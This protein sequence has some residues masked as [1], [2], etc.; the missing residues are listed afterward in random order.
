MIVDEYT[1]NSVSLHGGRV[2]N[3]CPIYIH[4][5][6]LY[7]KKYEYLFSFILLFKC[8]I[9]L[10]MDSVWYYNGRYAHHYP[11]WRR[12]CTIVYISGVYYE[13]SIRDGSRTNDDATGTYR[14]IGY[15]DTCVCSSVGLD[16]TVTYPHVPQ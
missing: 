14:C 11:K 3:D 7:K 6:A 1:L 9:L 4:V 10:F 5:F 13:E 8:D 2:F 16:G 12:N 15:R